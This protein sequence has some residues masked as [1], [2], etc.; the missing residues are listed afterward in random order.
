MLSLPR[1]GLGNIKMFPSGE[2]TYLPGRN[3]LTIPFKQYSDDLKTKR[4]YFPIRSSTISNSVSDE[5]KLLNYA[6]FED[7]LT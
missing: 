7:Q 1:E 3:L 4:D 6:N 2:E 5:C